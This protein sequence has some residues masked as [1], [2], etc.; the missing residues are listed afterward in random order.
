MRLSAHLP[1]DNM[2]PLGFIDPLSEKMVFRRKLFVPAKVVMRKI[3]SVFCPQPSPAAPSGQPAPQEN[4][5]EGTNVSPDD[6]PHGGGGVSAKGLGSELRAKVGVQ[7]RRKQHGRKQ[8]I[9][10][11]GPNPPFAVP[12]MLVNSPEDLIKQH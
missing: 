2:M 3:H 6:G 1:G 4:G 9:S 11:N 5:L 10:S 7:E 8:L 12:A